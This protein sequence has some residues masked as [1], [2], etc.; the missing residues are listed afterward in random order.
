MDAQ[1]FIYSEFHLEFWSKKSRLF[2]NLRGELLPKTGYRIMR[3]KGNKKISIYLSGI[4][5]T[6]PGHPEA[7]LQTGRETSWKQIGKRLPEIMAEFTYMAGTC[8]WR[9]SWCFT[10]RTG[11]CGTHCWN[12]MDIK[13]R[14]LRQ[15]SFKEGG[16]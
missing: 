16:S 8:Y 3:R 6:W 13:G 4:G 15:N 5:Q 7:C 14:D 9:N 11:T 2:N 1:Y 10:Q 12:R